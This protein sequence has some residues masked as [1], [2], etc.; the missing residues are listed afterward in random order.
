MTNKSLCPLCNKTWDRCKCKLDE[1]FG[2]KVGSK[3]EVAWKK[4][5]DE[6]V[7]GI[8]AN[9]KSIELSELI[10]DYAKKRMEEE[11]DKFINSKS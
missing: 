3:Q 8:E 4:T 11:H 9:K 6:C 7:E 5:Y 2:L 10:R 1:D